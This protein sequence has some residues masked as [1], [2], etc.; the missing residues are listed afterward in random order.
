VPGDETAKSGVLHEGQTVWYGG[1]QAVFVG[2]RGSSAAVI[3]F[4][5]TGV[6]SGVRATKLGRTRRESLD[7][8]L[9][10]GR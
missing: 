8:A 4:T 2:Y 5:E 9:V 6:E 3:R 7:L 1:K 10:S